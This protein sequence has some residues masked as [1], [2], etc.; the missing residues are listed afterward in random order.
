MPSDA[1]GWQIKTQQEIDEFNKNCGFMA[2][3]AVTAE[4]ENYFV[5]MI[6]QVYPLKTGNAEK[7]AM[8]KNFCAY[9]YSDEA[10]GIMA[11]NNAMVPITNRNVVAK[12]AGMS[13]YVMSLFG[14]EGKPIFASLPN[15]SIVDIP[16]DS[17]NKAVVWNASFKQVSCFGINPVMGSTIS[18]IAPGV[19]PSNGTEL[20][21]ELKEWSQIFNNKYTA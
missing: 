12:A 4:Q 5:S 16:K 1:V 3:P 10:A 18:G 20:F 19:A 7:E 6:E 2:F 17:D 13:D 8:A 11:E 9:L 15:G 21:N 14:V